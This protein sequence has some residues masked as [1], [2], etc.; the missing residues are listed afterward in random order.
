MPVARFG[1]S[2]PPDVAKE[3]DEVIGK[4]GYR[5]RSKAILDAIKSF[6]A[7]LKWMSGGSETVVGSLSFLYNHEV[8]GLE[9]YL[10]DVEHEFR[11]VIT[12]TLHVH[13]S[14]RLCHKIIAVRGSAEDIKRLALK[15]A[16]KKGV[17]QLK[18]NISAP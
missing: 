3:F 16:S 9:E 13:V 2:L 15:V 6:L 10:T 17:E 18:I 4:M 1:V 14:E 8:K 12:A 7:D 5:N 11:G